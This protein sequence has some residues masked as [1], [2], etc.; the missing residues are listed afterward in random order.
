MYTSTFL[1]NGQCTGTSSHCKV[2]A[3]SCCHCQWP[4]ST[5]FNN[6]KLFIDNDSERVAV[7]GSLKTPLWELLVSHWFCHF[8]PTSSVSTCVW[9]WGQHLTYYV[10][11]MTCLKPDETSLFYV[12]FLKLRFSNVQLCSIVKL[13]DY[14]GLLNP[15]EGKLLKP[16]C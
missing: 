14:I 8:F 9:N 2:K 12:R 1:F 11:R 5:F 16:W 13:L 6:S 7:H 15:I 10:T 4:L 3:G